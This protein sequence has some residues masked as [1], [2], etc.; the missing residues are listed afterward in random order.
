MYC[1]HKVSLIFTRYLYTYITHNMRA[2]IHKVRL[3]EPYH[4]SRRRYQLSNGYSRLCASRRDKATFIGNDH[5]LRAVA[6]IQF[7]QKAADIGTRGRRADKEIFSD[8][9]VRLP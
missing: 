2:K 8:F 4:T 6:G 3:I 7:R 5:Q 9:V 1:Y